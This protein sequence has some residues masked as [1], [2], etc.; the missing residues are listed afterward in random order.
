MNV[1]SPIGRTGDDGIVIFIVVLLVKAGQKEQGIVIVDEIAVFL[2]VPFKETGCRNEAAT[3]IT[4]EAF[5][6]DAFNAGIDDLTVKDVVFPL[7]QGWRILL[8][9]NHV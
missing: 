3:G 1:E 2:L 9:Q 5:I 4:V 6:T 7:H 8:I